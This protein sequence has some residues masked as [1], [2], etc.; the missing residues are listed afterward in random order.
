MYTVRRSTVNNP[1]RL[2][3]VVEPP[4]K[5]KKTGLIVLII[6]IIVILIVVVVLVVFFLRR[7]ANASTSTST[8]TL[9][10]SNADCTGGKKCNVVTGQCIQCFNDTDCSGATPVCNLATATCIAGCTVDSD[11]SGATPVCDTGAKICVAGC[12][13]SADCTTIAEPICDTVNKTCVGCLF[14]TDCTGVSEVCEPSSKTCVPGCFN[15]T[16]CS[17]ATPVCNLGTNLCVACLANSDCSGATPACDLGTNICVECTNN[18]NCSGNTPVCKIGTKTC[19]ACLTNTDCT[20]PASICNTATNVCAECFTDADCTLPDTC[21]TTTQQCCVETIQAPITSFVVVQIVNAFFQPVPEEAILECLLN[22][23]QDATKV[24]AAIRMYSQTG[25]FIGKSP[26]FT[27]LNN[28]ANT[29]NMFPM[30]NGAL[31][32]GKVIYKFALEIR[33]GCET[34]TEISPLTA[35]KSKDCSS[36]VQYYPNLTGGSASAGSRSISSHYSSQLQDTAIAVCLDRGPA[37]PNDYDYIFRNV[38]SVSDGYG[39]YSFTVTIPAGPTITSG[40][41]TYAI[42]GFKETSCFELA[43]G[44]LLNSGY[45]FAGTFGI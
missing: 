25:V 17:G 7:R 24:K 42:W 23:P 5:K 35:D 27:P 18:A 6:I 30:T 20:A 32:H 1:R 43:T 4:P 11:C 14:N 28:V 19:V 40:V 44:N 2:Q 13:T 29:V 36:A 34:W 10:K 21:N 45:H 38:P 12:V 22:I 31:L 3:K 33:S 9:C 16:D 15:N 26:D 8:P 41:T 39:G 37:Y